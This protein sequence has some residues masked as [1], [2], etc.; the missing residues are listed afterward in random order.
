MRSHRQQAETRLQVVD[1]ALADQD[2]ETLCRDMRNHLEEL[3][4]AA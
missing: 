4:M 3:G 2:Y 1:S